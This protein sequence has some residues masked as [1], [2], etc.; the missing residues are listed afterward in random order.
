[1]C[2]FF[3][4]FSHKKTFE[5]T[6][7]TAQSR[8]CNTRT[9]SSSAGIESSTEV[10]YGCLCYFGVTPL[11]FGGEYDQ[12]TSDH[13]REKSRRR[14]HRWQEASIGRFAAWKGV[15][16]L[17]RRCFVQYSAPSGWYDHS[18]SVQRQRIENN[19]RASLG[20]QLLWKPSCWIPAFQ[21]QL[22]VFRI[23]IYYCM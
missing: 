1:M 6:T 5:K 16:K 13:Q 17:P 10:V 7:L 14:W 21:M 20:C 11:S 18:Y 22:V 23:I 15:R 4:V 8:F 3:Y 2:V 9:C 19:D 12:W